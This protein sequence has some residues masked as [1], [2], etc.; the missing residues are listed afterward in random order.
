M[1]TLIKML[2]LHLI[3]Y[4]LIYNRHFDKFNINQGWK[5]YRTMG[6]LVPEN[7]LSSQKIWDDPTCQKEEGRVT[8]RKENVGNPEMEKLR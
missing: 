2:N 3:P 7:F 4:T 1:E 8:L 5:K 6:P